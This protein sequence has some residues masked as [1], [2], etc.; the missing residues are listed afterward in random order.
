[1]PA[2]TSSA[3]ASSSSASKTSTPRS[4]ITCDEGGVLDLGLANP[5][6]VVEEQLLGVRRGEPTVLETGPVDDHLAQ[7]PDLGVDREPHLRLPPR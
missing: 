6:D 5:D 1:M 4:R 2:G 7:V 3:S